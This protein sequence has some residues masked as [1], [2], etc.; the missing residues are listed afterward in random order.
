M[1]FAVGW[2]GDLTPT[3]HDRPRRGCL[4]RDK[5]TQSLLGT[6]GNGVRATRMF[7]TEDR[8]WT[9]ASLGSFPQ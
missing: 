4:I 6:S 2:A 9:L 8:A 3:R 7:S 1:W 5:S